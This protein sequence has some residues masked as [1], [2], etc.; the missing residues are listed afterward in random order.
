VIALVAVLVFT[1]GSVFDRH[2]FKSG[3][4]AFDQYCRVGL[5]WLT[6]LGIAI[7]FRER[8]NIRI[9]LLD[10]FLARRWVEPKLIGLDLIVLGVAGLM[11][12]VGWRL[13]EVGAFQVL[14]DTPFTYESMYGAL[15]FGLA[16]LCVFLVARVVDGLT[17][18]R[19]R[20][21]APPAD[22]DHH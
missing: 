6:F 13:L 4:F 10:H 19:L 17:A 5:V 1:V 9:D 15:L 22:H 8:A 2:F 16:V 11:I 7:G 12:V 14:M 18:S 20:L 3:A 21:D